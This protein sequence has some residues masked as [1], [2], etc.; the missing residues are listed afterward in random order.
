MGAERLC[1]TIRD[2]AL[3][4]G[5]DLSAFREKYGAK[6][7]ARDLCGPGVLSMIH[8]EFGSASR[9]SSPNPIERMVADFERHEIAVQVD[10]LGVVQV[11]FV[12]CPMVVASALNAAAVCSALDVAPSRLS[13]LL[14]GETGVGKEGFAHAI[15]AGS[16]RRGPLVFF[17]CARLPVALADS[18]L[19]GHVRGAFTS[20]DRSHRGLFEEA[21]GGTLVLDELGELGIE[22]QAKLL[23][24]LEVGAVRRVGSEKDVPID[25]RVIALTNRDLWKEVAQ[26]R[27]RADLYFRIAQHVVTVPPLRERTEEVL[28][29]AIHFARR[30][31]ARARLH[32]GVVKFLNEYRWPGN[33]R[34]LKAAIERAVVLASD[35]DGASRAPRRP[36]A[37]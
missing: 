9:S 6:G 11:G 30:Q 3:I 21:H 18:Q 14:G 36:R 34:Q 33:V 20:A 25:V 4:A 10:D 29:L 17:N 5:M 37:R 7:G 13:V 23:R 31:D 15:H 26:G 22:I 19:F 12:A 28:P 1:L 35:T 27:F 8:Q 24:V 32:P 16:K 2:A